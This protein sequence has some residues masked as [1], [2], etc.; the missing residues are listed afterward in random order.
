MKSFIDDENI[1]LEGT[2]SQISELGLSYY[3]I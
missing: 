3:I 1:A 2:V